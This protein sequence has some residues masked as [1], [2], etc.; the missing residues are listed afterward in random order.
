MDG[1]SSA[2]AW[3]AKKRRAPVKHRKVF[4]NLFPF[5]KLLF[6]RGFNKK[7]PKPII[8]DPGRPY[9]VRK[10]LEASMSIGESPVA[11]QVF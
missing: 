7:S 3:Q 1:F 8:I 9:F 6:S 10:I 4:F 11:R 5:K 2:S